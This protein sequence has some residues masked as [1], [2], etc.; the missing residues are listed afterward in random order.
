MDTYIYTWNVYDA[1]RW[2]TRVE[3]SFSF[4]CGAPTA[5]AYCAVHV[6]VLH[7]KLDLALRTLIAYA[8]FKGSIVQLMLLMLAKDV[9]LSVIIRHT[10]I[11][12]TNITS[13]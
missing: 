10:Q 5:R 8:L 6:H 4:I 12:V 3:R 9:K 11:I 7:R 1:C 2:Q 13:I